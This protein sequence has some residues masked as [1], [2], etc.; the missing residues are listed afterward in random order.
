MF[1]IAIWDTVEKNLFLA[2]DR[3]GKKPL[4]FYRKGDRFAFASEIKAILQMPDIDRSIRQDAVKDFFFY[5]YVPETKSIFKHIEKVQAGHWMMVDRDGIK[6]EQYWDV[7]FGK[8]TDKSTDEIQSDLYDLLDDSVKTRMISDVPLGAF[9]SGGVDSSAVVGL[10]AK[11]SAKPVTTCAIGFDSK[12][13]D[14]V[15]YA[16]K[17]A[18]QFNTDHHELTVKENVA[19]NLTSIAKYF[20]EPFA[21]PSFVPTYF[22]SKLARS[23]V[24]VALAGDGG[25]EN[26]AGYGKYQHDQLENK[27]RDMVPSILGK[28]LF[29]H[30]A[31]ILADRDNR[32]LRRGASLLGSLSVPADAG[33]FISNSFFTPAL[34]DCLLY[35]SPSPRDQRGS[36][37]PSSA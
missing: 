24:T 20:D 3:L 35:T 2:R 4:Y 14:E 12:K 26:F 10:M 17:V 29:R 36:R 27:I 6:S 23:M 19:D 15:A 22:V 5:Q 30:G 16:A 8:T 21:D 32:Q 11:N 25:D 34:W 31:K 13:F 9:L 7:S 1:S 37:M 18:T 33:F 28:G